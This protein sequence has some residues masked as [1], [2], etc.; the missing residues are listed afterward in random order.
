MLDK[1]LYCETSQRVTEI[2]DS[3]GLSARK[4]SNE[5]SISQIFLGIWPNAIHADV[6]ITIE[7][8]YSPSIPIR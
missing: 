5:E 8:V 4:K 7:I 2:V 1:Y 6:M 3:N